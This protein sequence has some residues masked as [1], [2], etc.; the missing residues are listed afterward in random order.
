MVVLP[1]PVG[2]VTKIMPM[3]ALELAAEAGQDGGRHPGLGQRQYA[4]GLIQQPHHHGIPCTAP[5]W[6]TSAHPRRDRALHG[7]AAILGQ[8]PPRC[9]A[10]PP[11]SDAAPAPGRC[12]P[13][14]RM[15]SCST[16]SMRWRD[17]QHLLVRLDVKCPRPPPAPHP[18][19]ERSSFGHRR[20]PSRPGVEAA[21][22][23][24]EAGLLMLR[25]ACT[26]KFSISRARR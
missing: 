5:A 16:P 20:R 2:P 4:G 1:L 10:P 17:A 12:V 18:R 6:W 15:F 23:Q 19:T 7:E 13:S 26:A 9:R 14:L 25:A 11:A 8:P 24:L 3:R 22:T 21:G